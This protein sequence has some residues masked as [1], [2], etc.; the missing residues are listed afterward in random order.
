MSRRTYRAWVVR[1]QPDGHMQRGIE[2]RSTDDL[3]PGDV[4]IRVH[5]SSLNYKDA[6]SATGNKGVT[7]RFPHT[8]GIDAAGVVQHSEHPDLTIG[9]KV[10]VSGYDLGMNTPGGHGEYIRTPA[11]WVVPL[12]EGLSLKESMAYG[13]AGFTAALSILRMRHMDILPDSGEIL[14]TGASGGVGSIAVGILARLGY[15]VTAMTRR[16][17]EM[18][19][20]GELGAANIAR[21]DEVLPTSEKPLAKGRWAAVIDTV[22]GRYW[23][24]QSARPGRGGA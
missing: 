15:R 12:P 18:A 2:T 8:T 1:E 6:L 3:P 20:L 11:S 22:A 13:T 17:T 5:Y 16:P 23:T 9:Q 4:L 14:V 10:I 21:P 7:A 24:A 19:F